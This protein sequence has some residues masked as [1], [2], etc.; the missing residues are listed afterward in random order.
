MNEFVIWPESGL[1][2]TFIKQKRK[3]LHHIYVVEV[4]NPNER[5]HFKDGEPDPNIY[6]EYD[7]SKMS[8]NAGTNILFLDDKY[9]YGIKE[10]RLLTKATLDPG[11]KDKGFVGFVK[12]DLATNQPTI[13]YENAKIMLD[14]ARKNHIK[15][16]G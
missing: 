9:D 11:K 16:G 6:I 14:F 13:K 10:E 12:N 7:M 4:E 5:I 15:R 3:S 1:K 2:I 8:C